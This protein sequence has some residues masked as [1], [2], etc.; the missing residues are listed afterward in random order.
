MVLARPEINRHVEYSP[1]SPPNP[2]DS[3]SPASTRTAS[4]L[5]GPRAFAAPPNGD[6][7]NETTGWISNSPQK[8]TS[9]V[10]HREDTPLSS[11]SVPS[12]NSS[13]SRKPRKLRRRSSK[14]PPLVFWRS[15]SKSPPVEEI[16]PTP[17][18]PVTVQQDEQHYHLY[19]IGTRASR[20]VANPRYS[21][22]SIHSLSGHNTPRT[23]LRRIYPPPQTKDSPRLI[24]PNS[25]CQAPSCNGTPQ[26]EELLIK[27]LRRRTSDGSLSPSRDKGH[28]RNQSVPSFDPHTP[29]R[30]DNHTNGYAYQTPS[31]SEGR[32]IWLVSEN[33]TSQENDEFGSQASRRL[34]FGSRHMRKSSRSSSYRDRVSSQSPVPATIPERCESLNWDSESDPTYESMKVEQDF[35]SGKPRLSSLFDETDFEKAVIP[36]HKSPTTLVRILS[37]NASEDLD[38]GDPLPTSNGHPNLKWRLPARMDLHTVNIPARSTSLSRSK[39]MSHPRPEASSERIPKLR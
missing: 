26:K 8:K 24:S 19:D 30:S 2:R 22:A 3:A 4:P 25:L 6:T 7:R 28:R 21:I 33:E 35:R 37:D 39:S 16:P 13:S 11:E 32:T 1:S 27:A 18:P 36:D 14:T 10:Y 34:E 29:T 31:R 5:T 17:S 9:P 38:W 15:K 12:P 20:Y 23:P